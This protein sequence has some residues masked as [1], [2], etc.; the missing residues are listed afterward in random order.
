MILPTAKGLNFDKKI[1]LNGINN[2][3]GNVLLKQFQLPS[4]ADGGG[5]NFL[6]VTELNNRRC[7]FVDSPGRVRR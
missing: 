6:A 7:V 4:D 5:I 3:D 2:F 1:T